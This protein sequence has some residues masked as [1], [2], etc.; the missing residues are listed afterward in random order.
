MLGGYKVNKGWMLRKTWLREGLEY[1][2]VIAKFTT[3]DFPLL[4]LH[5]MFCAATVKSW[6]SWFI[7]K[8]P[9]GQICL[10]EKKMERNS[11]LK[12]CLKEWLL[13][14]VWSNFTGETND[15]QKIREKVNDYC[16]EKKGPTTK[17]IIGREMAFSTP[18]FITSVLMWDFQS[19]NICV[20]TSTPHSAPDLSEMW[21]YIPCL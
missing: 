1:L 17:K 16:Y 11:S 8:Q 10:D 21:G 15:K 4:L 6:I 20:F 3:L 13:N 18:T 12:G 2:A 5:R 14:L 19:T 7:Q 9:R